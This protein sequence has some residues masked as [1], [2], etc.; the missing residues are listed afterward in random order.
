MEPTIKTGQNSI[1]IHYRLDWPDGERYSFSVEPV[2]PDVGNVYGSLNEN[3]SFVTM[4][5]PQHTSFPFVAGVFQAFDFIKTHLDLDERTA[6]LMT[7]LMPKLTLLPPADDLVKLA[8]DWKSK[9]PY[10]QF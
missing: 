9:N 1:V 6:S 7:A 4:T 8:T 3:Y 2:T 5:Y 10:V